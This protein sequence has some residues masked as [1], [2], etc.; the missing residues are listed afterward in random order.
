MKFN[1]FR[2]SYV[3]GMVSGNTFLLTVESLRG[4]LLRKLVTTLLGNKPQ[5]GTFFPTFGVPQQSELYLPHR[6]NCAIF[7]S[8]EGGW[9]VGK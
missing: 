2:A 3:G 5:D 8:Q 7:L 1:N 6:P 4:R 9:N